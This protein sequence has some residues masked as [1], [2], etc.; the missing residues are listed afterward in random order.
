MGR[1][2]AGQCQSHLRYLTV[3]LSPGHLARRSPAS[4]R[5]EGT[6]TS[7]PSWERITHPGWQLVIRVRQLK[8]SHLPLGI[9]VREPPQGGKYPVSRAGTIR[10]IRV[11][12]PRGMA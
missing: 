5:G 3:P 6:A 9:D 11:V 1:A 4:L 7:L 8:P 10:F 2:V 12:L